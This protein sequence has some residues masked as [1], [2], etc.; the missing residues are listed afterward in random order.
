MNDENSETKNLSKIYNIN[1]NKGLNDYDN[2]SLLNEIDKIINKSK[3]QLEE[4]QQKKLNEDNY[5]QCDKSISNITLKK[6]N[7][8]NITNNNSQNHSI[9]NSIS[10]SDNLQI[11]NN[12]DLEKDFNLE[13]IN[14]K[15]TTDLTMERVKVR[16]LTLKLS[17]KEK[18]ISSLKQ[19]IKYTQMNCYNK[20]K[21]LE[22]ILEQKA[23]EIPESIKTSDIKGKN[24]KINFLNN[25]S[26]NAIIVKQFFD[27]FNKYIDL[28]NQSNIFKNNYDNILIYNENDINGMNIKNANFAINTLDILIEKL[29]NDNKELFDQVMKYKDIVN[30]DENFS[31]NFGNSSGLTDIKNIENIKY[32]NILLKNQLQK[33]I[34]DFKNVKSDNGNINEEIILS[35]GSDRNLIQEIDQNNE[36]I[37]NSS[38]NRNNENYISDIK[39]ENSQKLNDNEFNQNLN[40]NSKNN[41]KDNNQNDFINVQL[42]DSNSKNENNKINNIS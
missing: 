29:I 31:N 6:S 39:N 9:N 21:H 12:N 19:Q 5:F 15:L 8:N 37:N 1:I 33:L 24:G 2:Y 26:D 41:I 10:K 22:K 27:F 17:Q 7:K 23:K 36:D 4:I 28:Y 42:N 25:D 35:N 13:R 38:S 18:E 30:E 3:I 14:L 11:N 32:E 34:D 20:Q 40:E 16:D